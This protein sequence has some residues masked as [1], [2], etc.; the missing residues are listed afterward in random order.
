MP[1]IRTELPHAGDLINN[2][3]FVPHP[4]GGKV[5]EVSVPADLAAI[6]CGIPGFETCPAPATFAVQAEPAA[7]VVV[8]PLSIEDRRAEVD[9]LE[10]LIAEHLTVIAESELADAQSGAADVVKQDEKP[11]EEEK[12]AEL[13]NPAEEEKPA[14]KGKK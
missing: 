6:F 4:D 3:R 8:L 14:I 7:E 10:A 9:R 2:V 13:E 1:F 11:A 12:P 5:S